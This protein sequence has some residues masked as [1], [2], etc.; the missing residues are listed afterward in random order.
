LDIELFSLSQQNGERHTGI[1]M[2]GHFYLKF[3]FAIFLSL[4]IAGSKAL[5]IK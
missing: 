2:K 5:L 1:E 4:N 3:L